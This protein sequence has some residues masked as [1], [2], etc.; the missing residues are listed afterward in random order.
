[1]KNTTPMSRL[2]GHFSRMESLCRGVGKPIN[3]HGCTKRDA[4]HDNDWRYSDV[5]QGVESDFVR[6]YK[7]DDSKGVSYSLGFQFNYVHEQTPKAQVSLEGAGKLISTKDLSTDDLR[8]IMNHLNRELDRVVFDGP[9]GKGGMSLFVALLNSIVF[10]EK[11]ALDLDTEERESADVIEQYKEAVRDRNEGLA[12]LQ[13][14]LKKAE[15][16]DATVTAE[17][18]ATVDGCAESVRIK[19]IELQIQALKEE[20]ITL[21]EGVNEHRYSAMRKLG[22]ARASNDVSDAK[23]AI[24]DFEHGFNVARNKILSGL[25]IRLRKKIEVEIK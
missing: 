2:S 3:F 11:N 17:L 7:F 23:R 16:K 12:K 19:E 9:K 4:Y 14:R 25:S 15:K 10:S 18:N 1:M 21:R 24:E 20:L 13:A 22:V 8:E 6:L 5:R